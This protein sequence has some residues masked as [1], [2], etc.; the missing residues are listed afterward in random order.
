MRT[1]D[2]GEKYKV[3]KVLGGMEGS[4]DQNSQTAKVF[5]V[6]PVGSGAH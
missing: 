3:Q 4:G 6:S 5:G 1:K 2:A